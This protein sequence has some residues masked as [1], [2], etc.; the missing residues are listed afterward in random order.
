[1][2][3]W[4]VKISGSDIVNVYVSLHGNDTKTWGSQS[5][6]YLSI[7]QAVY[8]VGCGGNIY[9]YGRGTKKRPYGSKNGPNILMGHPGIYNYVNKSLIVRGFY[10]IQHVSCAK[11]FRVQLPVVLVLSGIA[12]QQT[13][14]NCYDCQRI[15]IHNCSFHKASRALAIKIQNITSF[16]LDFKGSS[17]FQN[18]SK[19]ISFLL[20]NI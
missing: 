8:F 12:F 4:F 20:L 13:P 16:Q 9:L 2:K 7:A 3:L 5:L 10:S 19:F 15:T 18:N 11:G 14:L 6:P 17:T 1:M